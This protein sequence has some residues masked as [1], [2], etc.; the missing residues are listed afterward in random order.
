[1]LESFIMMLLLNFV[2]KNKGKL[3]YVSTN[4]QVKCIDAEKLKHDEYYYVKAEDS[5]GEVSHYH[6]TH[7]LDFGER[8]G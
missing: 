1:M 5:D 7:F 3:V 6:V 2:K 4:E 8:R